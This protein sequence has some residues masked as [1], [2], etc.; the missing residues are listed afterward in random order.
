[1]KAEADRHF[2]VGV[3]QLIGHGWPY[4]PDEAGSP[5]WRFYAAAVFNQHNPWWTVMP[6]ISLYLQ[7]VS[8]LMR[9]GKPVNDVALYLPTED[10][11]AQLAPGRVSIDQ[12]MDRLLGPNVVPKILDAGYGFDF[13]DDQLLEKYGNA[14]SGHLVVNGNRYPIVVLP[15]VERIPL[16]TYRKLEEF[17]RQGGLLVALRRLPSRAPGFLNA[18]QETQEIR[19]ISRRL[20]TGDSPAAKFLATEEEEFPLGTLFVRRVRPDVEFSP[21][22]PDIGFVHRSTAFAEIY[23]LANTSSERREAKA[24]FRVTGKHPEWWNPFTGNV[25]LA[26]VTAGPTD[27][28]TLALVLEPYE[29]RVLV[30]TDRR[31]PKANRTVA[32]A[33]TLPQPLDLSAGWK[34]TFGSPNGK[35]TQMDKLRSWTDDEETRYFSGAA[36]YER[37]VTVPANF[38]QQ[39]IEVSLDFG[40]GTPLERREI[41]LGMRAWLDAPVRD[42]A[43]VYVNGQRAG[44]VW[45]APFAVDVTRLLRE[46]ENSLRVV[47]SN[48][49]IN[50]LAGTTL[51]DYRLLRLRYGERFQPQD[52]ENLHPV[53]SGLLGTVRLVPREAGLALPAP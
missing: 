38:L 41:R 32:A 37:A 29:S 21:V 24:T 6:D 28:T 2:L 5:G 18:E 34:V 19:E 14:E 23:F 9:Q 51:P 39:G 12:A 8:F 42:A 46:G 36:V 17:V 48:T 30:F 35:T 50:A 25:A 31:A 53:P 16:A 7:R 33:T 13:V 3:N 22:M 43:V 47:V 45:S 44:S 10:A 26:T 27:G 15:N 4:S 49:A 40:A 20:F 1:M 11:W 52:M